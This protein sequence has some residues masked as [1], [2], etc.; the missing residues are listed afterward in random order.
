MKTEPLNDWNLQLH[1][2]PFPAAENGW[3]TAPSPKMLTFPLQVLDLI[4]SNP[5]GF[6]ELS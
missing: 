1:H 3:Q 5:S 4:T 2:S 6:T